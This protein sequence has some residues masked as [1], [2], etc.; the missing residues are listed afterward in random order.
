MSG[1]TIDLDLSDYRRFFTRLGAAA[2]GEFKR[3]LAVFVDG[4]GYEFLRI[5]Q[6]LIIKRK[7]SLSGQ[8]LASF[9]KGGEGSVWDLSDDD[10]TLEVGTNVEYA[11]W[12]N[13]GHE[14]VNP[15]TPG[16]FFLPDG[17]LARFVPGHWIVR[18]DGK[19]E[20][21]YSGHAE[22]REREDRREPLKR[23]SA[24]SGKGKTRNKQS[25]GGMILT[26]GKVKGSKF[27]EDAL[28]VFEKVYPGFLEAKLQD[29]LDTYFAD[30]K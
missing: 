5:L 29:W 19:S 9:E 24:T 28:E 14:K 30:F 10:L 25:E 2:G 16:A 21:I 26:A 12:A 1:G 4:L 13:D 22:R 3:E 27:W 18:G 7:V 23:P 17:R 20:F 15:D 6:D 11:K 8:L